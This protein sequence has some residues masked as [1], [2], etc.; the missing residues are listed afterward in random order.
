MLLAALLFVAACDSSGAI[1]VENDWLAH[2]HD[3]TALDHILAPDF[4]H[5]LGSGQ[6]ISKADH[7][8]WVSTHQPPPTEQRRFERLD[9]RVFGGTAVATGIVAAQIGAAT[10]RTIFTDIFACRDS[11]WQAVGAQETPV[12]NDAPAK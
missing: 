4:V 7:I 9:V 6:F 12:G 1:A 11:R 3:A 2:E 10:H 5:A 8:G